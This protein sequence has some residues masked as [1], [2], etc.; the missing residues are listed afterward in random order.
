MYVRA[1]LGLP[2]IIIIIEIAI[3]PSWKKQNKKT[4]NIIVPS[5]I[6]LFKLVFSSFSRA[7][8]IYT[9]TRLKNDDSRDSFYPYSRLMFHIY[10][11]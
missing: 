1:R 7:P 5:N 11:L 6:L 2:I 4:L 10:F 8:I 3:T 9:K